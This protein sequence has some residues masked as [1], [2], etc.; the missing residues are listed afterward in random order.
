[1]HP[2]NEREGYF[3]TDNDGKHIT[4]A[5]WDKMLANGDFG[6]QALFKMPSRAVRSPF[7]LHTR[8]AGVVKRRKV[9]MPKKSQKKVLAKRKPTKTD[10]TKSHLTKDRPAE[11]QPARES[12]TA[13]LVTARSPPQIGYPVVSH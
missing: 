1:M 12:W 7:N 5:E 6:Q 13:N 2:V 8:S 10:P 11:N 4:E 3:L 9:V